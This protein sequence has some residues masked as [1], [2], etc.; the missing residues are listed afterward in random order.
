M[1]FIRKKIRWSLPLVEMKQKWFSSSQCNA[2]LKQPG[3]LSHGIFVEQLFCLV[4]ISSCF[5]ASK[6]WFIRVIIFEANSLK[7]SEY[8]LDITRDKLWPNNENEPRNFANMTNERYLTIRD[9]LSLSFSFSPYNFQF[10][11]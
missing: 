3:Y 10:V 8:I 11:L 1:I 5:C 7:G 6:T 4:K 2:T 9:S